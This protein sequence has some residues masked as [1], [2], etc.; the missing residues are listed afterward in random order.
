MTFAIKGKSQFLLSL[1]KE[2][3]YHLKNK[4]KKIIFIH[5]SDGPEIKQLRSHL[6][7]EEDQ[8]D[9]HFT[10]KVPEDLAS[11]IEPECTLICIDDKELHFSSKENWQQLY[12]LASFTVHHR[13]AHCFFTIQSVAAL[14]KDSVL[15]RSVSQSS[16]MV[17]FRNQH[18][19]RSMRTHLSNYSSLQLMGGQSLFELYQK[20]VQRARFM[21]IIV[22]ISAK[23]RVNSVYSNILLDSPGFMMAFHDDSENESD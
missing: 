8:V 2:R 5:S 15:N 13:M 23:A 1:I 6:E 19:A 3:K 18:D 11:L 9:A 22:N 21:Y 10:K 14:K 7:Q 16:H 4:I 12:N 20:Y 17:Y